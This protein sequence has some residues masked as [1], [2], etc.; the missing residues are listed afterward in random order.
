MTSELAQTF[1]QL[2]GALEWAGLV[3]APLLLLPLATLAFPGPLGG[4]AARLAAVIDRISGAALSIAIWSGIGLVLLQVAIIVLRF[5]FRV[6]AIDIGPVSIASPALNDLLLYLFAIG[7]LFASASALR[8]DGHVRVDILREQMGPRGRALADFIGTHLFLFPVM[9][10]VLLASRGWLAQSWRIFEGSREASGLPTYF[11][12]KTLIPAFALLLIL[13]GLA[14]ALR[15][16]AILRA[17][18]TDAPSST[19]SAPRTPAL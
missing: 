2:G 14:N 15:A 17:G 18:P 12:F 6:T 4:V 9:I 8:D 19:R 16:A 5:V 10:L 13:Q 7:F 3:A 11:L 1:L